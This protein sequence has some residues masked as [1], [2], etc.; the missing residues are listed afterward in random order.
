MNLSNFTKREADFLSLVSPLSAVPARGDLFRRSGGEL[1]FCSRPKKKPKN[2]AQKPMVFENFLPPDRRRAIS[3]GA[4]SS[5]I[6][7][8]APRTALPFGSTKTTAANAPRLLAY[9]AMVWR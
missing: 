2:A 9:I 8:A 7:A 1:L 6:S 3:L 5:S 4:R